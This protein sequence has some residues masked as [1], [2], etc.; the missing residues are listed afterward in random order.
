VADL[1]TLANAFS[2]EIKTS[3]GLTRI[4][5]LMSI[6]NDFDLASIHRVVLVPPYTSESVI[7]GQDVV[8]PHWDTIRPLVHQSFP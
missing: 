1:P 6:G 3:M 8:I 4:R 5:Q 7:A 2:G